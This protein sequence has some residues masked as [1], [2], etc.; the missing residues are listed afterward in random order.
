MHL[1]GGAELAVPQIAPG[2]HDVAIVG[3]VP[4]AHLPFC[5]QFEPRPIEVICLQAAF[6]RGALV[7]E[8][9]E[10]MARYPDETLV[11]PTDDG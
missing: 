8:R 3:Q 4:A 10:H 1:G 6:G 2:D 9:L 5:D 11:P 7:E